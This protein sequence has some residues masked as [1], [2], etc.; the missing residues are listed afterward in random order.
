MKEGGLIVLVDS[1]HN[2]ELSFPHQP[3]PDVNK[4]GMC[5]WAVR[6]AGTKKKNLNTHPSCLASTSERCYLS[7]TLCQETLQEGRL[8]THTKS[9]SRNKT[10]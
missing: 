1:S 8:S 6:S 4:T 10:I 3:P 7:F 2:Y 9:C 5:Y